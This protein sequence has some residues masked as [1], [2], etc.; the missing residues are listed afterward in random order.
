MNYK[1]KYIIVG[2]TGCC[3]SSILS[4]YGENTFSCDVVPTIGVDFI[5][6]NMKFGIDNIKIHIWDMAGQ[7]KFRSI[8][9]SYYRDTTGIILVFDLTNIMSFNNLK[10]WYRELEKYCDME[11]IS[12]MLVGNKSDSKDVK[13]DREYIIDFLKDRNIPF[14]LESSAKNNINI[15]LIF[16][17]LTSY[18]YKNREIDPISEFNTMKDLSKNHKGCCNIV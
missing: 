4:L 10:Y 7:E 18:I 11:K 17:K 2:E 1:Y 8:V 3:K 13:I 12:I 14:Y 15:S 6:K 16:E 9:R 5:S